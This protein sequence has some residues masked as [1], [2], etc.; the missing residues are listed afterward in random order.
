MYS[1]TIQVYSLSVLR[2]SRNRDRTRVG[3]CRTPS[4]LRAN[5][6]EARRS[7]RVCK[8]KIFS[9]LFGVFLSQI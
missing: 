3:S 2:S 9:A 7:P 4:Q 5:N 8:V 6:N 1:T